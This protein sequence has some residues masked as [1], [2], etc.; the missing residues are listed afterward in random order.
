VSAVN[1]ARSVDS[2]KEISPIAPP[3]RFA[4]ARDLHPILEITKG[5][6]KSH[7]FGA[8]VSTGDRTITV[9]RPHE[10]DP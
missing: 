3:G 4:H 6:V 1:L 2:M 7:L 9:V 10:Y 5:R 8:T